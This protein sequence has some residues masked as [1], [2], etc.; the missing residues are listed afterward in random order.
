MFADDMQ[1]IPLKFYKTATR[2]NKQGEKY[3]NT[4]S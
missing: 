4:R 1:K 2:I 3:K